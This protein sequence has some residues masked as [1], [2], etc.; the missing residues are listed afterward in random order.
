MI[1]LLKI[2]H[3]LWRIRSN[4]CQDFLPLAVSQT[5]TKNKIAN[6]NCMCVLHLY[7]IVYKLDYHS[8]ILRKENHNRDLCFIMVVVLLLL[9][10]FLKEVNRVELRANGDLFT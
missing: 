6:I 3:G 4:F 9:H 5:L 7:T 8:K 2:F 10:L 1:L